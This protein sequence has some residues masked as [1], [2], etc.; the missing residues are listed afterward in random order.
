MSFFGL[1]DANLER[2]NG[3]LMFENVHFMFYFVEDGKICNLKGKIEHE[4]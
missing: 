1:F 2:K 3:I 4:K